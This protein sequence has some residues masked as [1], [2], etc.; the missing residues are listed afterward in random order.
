MNKNKRFIV[1]TD[2]TILKT[3]NHSQSMRKMIGLAELESHLWRHS[4]GGSLMR[5]LIMCSYQFMILIETLEEIS[6]C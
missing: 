6:N 3:H 1:E 5:S 4:I 2:F